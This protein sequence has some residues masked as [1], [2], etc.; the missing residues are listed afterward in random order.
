MKLFLAIFI[1]TP[2]IEMYL[3]IKVGGLIGAWP[4]IGLV[5]L[6]AMIGLALLRQQGISTLVRAQR[7]MVS[8]EIPA[9]ELVEGIFLAVGGALLLTPGFMTDAIGFCCLIPGIRQL[10]ILWGVRNIHF[11][12]LHPSSKKAR[13]RS[14][15]VIEGEFRRND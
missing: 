12:Q 15:D 5:F 14:H 1:I 3:L 8:G 9:Q 2:I 7:R 6:T 4:T 10:I 11:T 13:Y